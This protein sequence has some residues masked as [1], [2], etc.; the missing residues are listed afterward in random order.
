MASLRPNTFP[1]CSAPL[2][3]VVRDWRTPSRNSSAFTRIAFGLNAPTLLESARLRGR[4][5]SFITWAFP[6]VIRSR[7]TFCA[8]C[9]HSGGFTPA[10]AWRLH[11]L[12]HPWPMLAWR[13][14][15]SAKATSYTQKSSDE[16][17]AGIA[18]RFSSARASSSSFLCGSRVSYGGGGGGDGDALGPPRSL[19]PPGGK[20]GADGAPP[21]A[22]PPGG[23]EGADGAP[24]A[25][26]G[27]GGT[28][29][30]PPPE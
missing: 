4:R 19:S 6:S 2:Q 8:C 30:K 20:G 13:F 16:S 21:G 29:N 23:T 25:P 9:M 26:G 15:P 28:P 3:S 11:G 18:F 5:S 27:G 17:P 12:M 10:F 14:P 7:N 1:V 22:Q 24:Y